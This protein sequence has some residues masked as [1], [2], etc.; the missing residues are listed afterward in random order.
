M[1]FS[2]TFLF[3]E[4]SLHFFAKYS[5]DFFRKIF[6]EFFTDFFSQNFSIFFGE[7]LAF[8]FCENFLFFCETDLSEILR[9]RE[10]SRKTFMQSY[11]SSVLV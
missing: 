3:F 5:H 11:A 10:N 7:I 8:L 4:I 6:A 2:Q 1:F 9:K